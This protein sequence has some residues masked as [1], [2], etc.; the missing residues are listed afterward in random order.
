MTTVTKPTDVFAAAVP[1]RKRKREGTT[2]DLATLP[3]ASPEDLAAIAAALR[4]YRQAAAARKQAEDQLRAARREL[5]PRLRR[6]YVRQWV[7]SGKRPASPVVVAAGGERLTYCVEDRSATDGV[8]L[9]DEFVKALRCVVGDDLVGQVE[10]QAAT[11]YEFD[12]AVLAEPG[13][14]EAVAT[15]IA[16]SS[17]SAEQ[18]SRLIVYRRR[19]STPALKS[20]APQCNDEPRLTELIEALGKS[21]RTYLKG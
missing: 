17:L 20:L 7:T 9:T 8:E 1:K 14:R 16:G 11:T 15:A 12:S 18:R 19:M 21:V 10:D 6:A 4:A 2:I 13:V 3:N 5:M